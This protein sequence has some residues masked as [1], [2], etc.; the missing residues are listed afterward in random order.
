MIRHMRSG[1]IQ[2]LFLLSLQ[3]SRIEG[4][5][6]ECKWASDS[7]FSSQACA[8]PVD[9]TTGLRNSP[10]TYEPY[11]VNIG[12]SSPAGKLCVYSASTYNNNHGLSVITTPEIAASLVDAVENHI[13]AWNERKHLLA[14]LGTSSAHNDDEN[15]EVPYEVRDVPGKGKGVVAT[16]LIKKTETIMVGFPVMVIYDKL[17]PLLVENEPIA[18]SFPLFQH[19]L[20]QLSDQDRLTCLAQSIGRDLHIVDDVHRTNAFGYALNGIAHK[21]LFPEIARINHGCDPKY[22]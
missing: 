1:T 21:G 15:L 17:F 10:W 11:C 5:R 22:V 18:E 13:L 20:N 6:G 3:F 7:T 2:Y 16:R 4:H 19:A 14:G 9:D 8:L 12:S